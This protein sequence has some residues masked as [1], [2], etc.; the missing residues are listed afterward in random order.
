VRKQI[1]AVPEIELEQPGQVLDMAI[2]AVRME[3][4]DRRGIVTKNAQ[5]NISED[6]L[7]QLRI[8]FSGLDGGRSGSVRIADLGPFFAS[9]G[10]P[11]D[12][13]ETM[14]GIFSQLDLELDSE[15]S[16]PES[17]DIL[18]YLLNF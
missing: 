13:D 9:A 12:M 16:F 14:I 6:D 17:I 3:N 8:I 1:F 10:F 11:A 15:V 4:S 2:T 7:E 18:Q 5:A